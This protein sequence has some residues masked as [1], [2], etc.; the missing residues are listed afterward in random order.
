MLCQTRYDVPMTAVHG[1]DRTAT[2]AGGWV[3][4]D[5]TF[6]ARLAL[7]RLRMDWNVKE[8][9]REVGVPAASWRAWER[10]GAMPRRQVEIAGLIAERTGCDFMWLLAGRRDSTSVTTTRRYAARAKRAPLDHPSTAPVG[11]GRVIARGGDTQPN[12]V[13]LHV[14][15]PPDRPI[16]R[17]DRARPRVLPRRMVDR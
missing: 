17:S 9:A 1:E 8:A 7:V 6:A 2:G 14:R 4:S 10:D 11:P 13:A 5:D 12:G 15:Q 16:T 3:V